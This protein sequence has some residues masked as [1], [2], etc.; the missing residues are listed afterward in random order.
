MLLPMLLPMVFPHVL[1][2]SCHISGRPIT[3]KTGHRLAKSGL[4]SMDSAKPSSVT[5]LPW[6]QDPVDQGTSAGEKKTKNRATAKR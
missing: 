1:L 5:R 3:P 4:G 2:L 6:I